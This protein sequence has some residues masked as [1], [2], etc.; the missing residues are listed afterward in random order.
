MKCEYCGIDFTNKTIKK[1]IG[2]S[3]P[4]RIDQTEK[5]EY[6]CTQCDYS[7]RSPQ[8][9]RL[10]V[11]V[12]HVG[13]RFKCE[14][15]DYTATTKNQIRVHNNKHLGV[16]YPCDFCPR[17]FSTQG[18]RRKHL[19]VLHPDQYIVYSCHLCSYRTDNKDLLQR[20]ISGKYGKHNS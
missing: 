1:H 15:C 18:S 19:A 13:T 3:H 5:Q 8:A 20:H 4:E 17:Q 16:K 9:L 11:K 10:H 7:A 6:K 2:A 12:K 14:Q